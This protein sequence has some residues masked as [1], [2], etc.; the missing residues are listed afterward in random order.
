MQAITI[1]ITPPKLNP[2]SRRQYNA[3]VF[4]KCCGRGIANRENAHVAIA[5]E[6]DEDGNVTFQPIPDHVL[7]TDSVEWGDFIGSHCQKLLPKTHKIS[8]KRVT[9]AWVKNGCP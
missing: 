8:Q 7:G 9:T 1:N 6:P 3:D 5:S 2:Y 4:C